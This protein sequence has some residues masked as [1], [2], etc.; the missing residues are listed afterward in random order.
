MGLCRFARRFRKKRWPRHQVA[1]RRRDDQRKDWSLATYDFPASPANSHTT[2]NRSQAEKDHL[3]A[4]IEPDRANPIAG[5]IDQVLQPAQQDETLILRQ[6]ALG[7]RL[8]S[9]RLPALDG[10]ADA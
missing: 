7:Q 10:S 4:R 8:L 2:I 1:F 9:G 5:R 6:P 3:A